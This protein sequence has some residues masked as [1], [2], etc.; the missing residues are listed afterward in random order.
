MRQRTTSNQSNTSL[1]SHLLVFLVLLSRFVCLCCFEEKSN[2]FELMRQGLTLFHVSH[3]VFMRTT[4]TLSPTTMSVARH[5]TSCL[6]A[7]GTLRPNASSIT[8]DASDYPKS[9]AGAGQLPLI[10]SP[11]ITN[12]KLYHVLIND[13]VA[14][15]LISLTAFKRLPI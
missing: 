13:G 15:N 10:V 11:T 12:I 6:G 14:L 9:M 1:F 4:L 3:Q 7:P 8:F 5:S 2:R